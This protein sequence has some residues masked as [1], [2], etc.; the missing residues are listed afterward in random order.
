[1]QQETELHWQLGL[2]C[3]T[4]GEG[5]NTLGHQLDANPGRQAAIRVV[6]QAAGTHGQAGLD[7]LAVEA[8]DGVQQDHVAGMRQQ[9]GQAPGNHARSPRIRLAL[10]PPKAKELL[11]RCR[12]RPA[13]NCW[14]GVTKCRRGSA[15]SASP[16]QRWGGSRPSRLS[17][18]SQQKAASSAPAAPRVWPLSGLL[19]EQGTPAGNSCCTARL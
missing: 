8:V 12:G 2:A 17:R 13:G 1:A 6:E 15:G 18:L 7:A 10:L 11:T 19:E 9:F 16:S 3:P 14:P 4:A 5:G